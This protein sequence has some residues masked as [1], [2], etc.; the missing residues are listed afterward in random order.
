M[1]RLQVPDQL[2][3]RMKFAPLPDSDITLNLPIYNCDPAHH[4][5]ANIPGL[6][7][8]QN[9]VDR[10]NFTFQVSVKSQLFRKLDRTFD[11]HIF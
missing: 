4:V 1:D 9:A 2:G 10:C 3:T 6:A 5:T 11:V 7:N 8:C